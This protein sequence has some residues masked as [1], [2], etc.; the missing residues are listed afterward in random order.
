MRVQTRRHTAGK[1]EPLAA[2]PAL[3]RLGSA[4]GEL[5]EQQSRA[6]GLTAQQARLLFIL[7]EKPAN[8][9]GLSSAVKVRK[10]TMT[11]LIDRMQELGLLT[12]TPDGADRRRLVVAITPLGAKKSKEFERGMRKSVTR[13]I[14]PLNE[15]ER[16][17]L[18]RLLSVV[19]GESERV[20]PS[21]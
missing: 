3:V 11:S 14:A 13:L 17:A 10:S 2:G 19:L 21:E 18:G 4:I 8:M 15:V 20:L 16:G 1:V 5:Y 6:I 9:L 7:A 12:R